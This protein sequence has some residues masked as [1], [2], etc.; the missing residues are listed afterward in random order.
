MN[1]LNFTGTTRLCFL[2][3]VVGLLQACTSVEE[4]F[5]PETVEALPILQEEIF[6]LINQHRQTAGMGSLEYLD[7]AYQQANLHTN[8]M[9]NQ[10]K[11]SH[12]NFYSRESFLVAHAGADEV[13]EN[14]AYAYTTATGVVNAWLASDSHRQVIE[15]DFTH[16]G[17]AALKSSDGRNF[18]TQLFVRR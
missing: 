3:L 7:L 10:N 2:L 1:P 4:E 17:I 6:D 14:V 8:Y 15:G 18:F 5:N 16:V 11:V 9:V 12:D 13:A